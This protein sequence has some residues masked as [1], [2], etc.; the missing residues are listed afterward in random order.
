MDIL[1]CKVTD[2]DYRNEG[3]ASICF[4]LKNTG[5]ILKFPKCEIPFRERTADTLQLL[6]NQTLYLESVMKKHFAMDFLC[7]DMRIVGPFE[8]SLITDLMRSIEDKRPPDRKNK[9]VFPIG[10]RG[11][12]VR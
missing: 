5:F 10:C 9:S 6:Q 8:E 7:A 3:N 2:F 1:T 11:L 12:L 4:G